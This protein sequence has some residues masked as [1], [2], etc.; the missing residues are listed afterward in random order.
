MAKT[1]LIIDTDP[2]MDD[3]VA[4]LTAFGSPDQI[5]VRMI[6]TVGGNVPVSMCTSN[7]LRVCEL[8]ER[9]DVPVHEGCPKALLRPSN[10][11]FHV[12]GS[13]G[14]G[15]ASLPEPT[16]AAARGHAVPAMIEAIRRSSEKVTI[17]GLAPLT[18]IALALTMAPDITDNIHAIIAMGGSFHGGNITPY[19]TYNFHSDPHAVHI[20]INSGA[21]VVMTSL[22]VARQLKPD[23]AW[24]ADLGRTG[25]PAGRFV[26]EL[27]HDS[28]LCFNDAAVI[29]YIL[30]SELFQCENIRVE[31]ETNDEV[32]MGQIRRIQGEP[33]VCFASAVDR[34]SAF[35][36][37]ESVLRNP[38]PATLR[39]KASVSHQVLS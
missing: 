37:I 20:V 17:A 10:A 21:P 27:W 34:D 14:L 29:L 39:S 35:K 6:A 15:K 31:I 7:A 12:H 1:H 5:D 11:V 8:A 38:M 16:M 19:A 32:R 30:D 9:R 26:S 28:P 3:A 25:A 13:N 2:G 36:R 18:N 23:P 4:L 33:N 22:E 24:L